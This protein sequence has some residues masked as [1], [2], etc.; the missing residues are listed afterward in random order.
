VCDAL[1]RL[2]RRPGWLLRWLPAY[3]TGAEEV[4]Y[5]VYANT[6]TGDPINYATPVATVDGLTWTSSPLAYP[7]TWKFG[8]RAF[9][10]GSGLEDHNLDCEVEII[11]DPNGN[12]ITNRPGFPTGLRALPVAGG[13]IKVEW[14]YANL[15]RRA[16]TP[17]GFHVYVGVGSLD[18]ASPVAS[19]A[20]TSSIMSSFTTVLT[21]LTSG[22]TYTIGVRAYNATAEEPNTMTIACTSDAIGPTA[23]QSL[24]AIAV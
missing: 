1:P 9:Y 6:G 18:Y 2:R 5:H 14:S 12:D 23:V 13:N 8:V 16:Q 7:G 19:V 3:T 20:Y 22:T 21:G 10:D 15:A 4:W 24:T 11:L 17:T